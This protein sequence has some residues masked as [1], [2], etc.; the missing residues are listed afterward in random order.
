MSM[1]DGDL[2]DKLARIGSILRKKVEPFGGIQVRLHFASTL[3]TLTQSFIFIKGDRHRRLFPV[4]PRYER[5]RPTQ[6]RV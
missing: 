2:F 6:I 4:A 1:V 3:Q 5:K